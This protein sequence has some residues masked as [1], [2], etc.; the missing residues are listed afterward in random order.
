MRDEAI[1]EL[2][3]QVRALGMASERVGH[4]FAAQN[5]LHP[6]DLR[7]LTLIN[8]AESHGHPLTARALAR[9]LNLSP[10]ALTHAIDKLV[11]S[12]HVVRDS[13]PNDR[14]IV[15]LRHA[16]HGLEVAGAFFQPLAEAHAEALAG[17]TDDELDVALRFLVNLNAAL[18]SFPARLREADPVI[19][20]RASEAGAA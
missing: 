4:A 18:E 13:D 6:T 15:V 2:V 7:A 8:R 10:G 5:G 11:A 3:D 19:L 20:P 16:P 14:R 1:R 9:A 17:Y 12:G